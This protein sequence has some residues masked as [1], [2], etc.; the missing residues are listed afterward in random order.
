MKIQRETAFADGSDVRMISS[1]I[2]AAVDSLSSPLYASASLRPKSA[3]FAPASRQR[4]RTKSRSG[5]HS[6]GFLWK[7]GVGSKC[8]RTTAHKYSSLESRVISQ[9]R[10]ARLKIDE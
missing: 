9:S 7:E 3:S 6:V 4:A 2:S 5:Y 10:W 1:K 8:L